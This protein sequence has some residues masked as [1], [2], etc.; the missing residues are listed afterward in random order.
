MAVE[1]PQA[2]GW[3]SAGIWVQALRDGLARYVR[4]EAAPIAQPFNHVVLFAVTYRGSRFLVGVDYADNAHIDPACVKQCLVYFRMQHAN[5]GYGDGR[6]VPGGY[7]TYPALYAHLARRRRSGCA[8]PAYDVYGRFGREPAAQI[9]GR[10]IS[11]LGAQKLF[12]YEGR[13]KTVRYGRYL[14][15]ITRA[16]ICLDLPGHGALCFRLVDY[17][18][19][20]ACII[21]YPHANRLPVP[22]VPGLHIAYTR[23]DLSDLVELCAYYLEHD[24]ARRHMAS[25]AREYFDAYLHRDQLASYYLHEIIAR[26]H[27]HS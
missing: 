22:L 27:V 17:L 24:E 19:M 23:P 3:P 5:A 2:Y 20:G 16:R 21:A 18:A 10:A 6:I 9:R 7:S 12:R 15:E 25:R 13:W 1:W 8:A 14:K 4:I 26:L 11:L